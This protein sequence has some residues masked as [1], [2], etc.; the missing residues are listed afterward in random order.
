MALRPS[1]FRSHCTKVQSLKPTVPRPATFAIW[2]HGPQNAQFTKRT[3]PALLVSTRTI[4]GS[5]PWKEVNSPLEINKPKT[6][7][8]STSTAVKQSS[9]TT[10]SKFPLHCPAFVL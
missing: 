1:L 8:S 2:S 5:A 4:V 9:E 7:E 10:P 6:A 3:T